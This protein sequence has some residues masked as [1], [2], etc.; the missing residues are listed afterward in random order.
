MERGG[1]GGREERAYLFCFAKGG[2]REGESLKG[3]RYGG[4]VGCEGRR[5]VGMWDTGYM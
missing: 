4:W 1:C 5:G 2:R 3:I